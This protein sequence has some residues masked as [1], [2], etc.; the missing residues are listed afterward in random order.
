M[1][2]VGMVALL[3]YSCMAKNLASVWAL[4][5]IPSSLGYMTLGCSSSLCI[6]LL[7]EIRVPA[8]IWLIF[9]LFGGMGGSYLGFHAC[10]VSIPPLSDN[11]SLT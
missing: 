5:T 2:V 10:Q 4:T 1:P 7:M 9:F 6:S 8:F 3:S 11:L